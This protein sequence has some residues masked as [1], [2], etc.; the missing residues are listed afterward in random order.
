MALRMTSLDDFWPVPNNVDQTLA[1]S[2]VLVDDQTVVPVSV[3]Y[4]SE[5]TQ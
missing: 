2:S 1:L 4:R 3:P 5:S